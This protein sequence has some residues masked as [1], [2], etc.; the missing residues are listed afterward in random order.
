MTAEEA[1]QRLA[2]QCARHE[3]CLSE[4]KEKL[5]RW[6]IENA[7]TSDIAARLEREGFVD[8][9]RYAKAFT[10]DKFHYDHWGRMKIKAALK[11]KRI[12]DSDIREALEKIDQ[13]QYLSILT[14]V[15]QK[16]SCALYRSNTDI[17]LD[18]DD[19]LDY[20][21]RQKLA[22][23]AVSRGFEPDLVFRVLETLD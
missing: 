8:E 16:K 9:N 22:R 5:L 7:A 10:H 15:V 6:G 11:Q 17:A 4:V 21:S 1:F 20:T 13:E 2:A 23:F 12:S 3:H 14:E 18:N 19:K